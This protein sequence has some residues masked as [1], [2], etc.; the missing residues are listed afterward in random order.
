VAQRCL[1]GK[2]G[3]EALIYFPER[4]PMSTIGGGGWGAGCWDLQAEMAM[5]AAMAR[6][7]CFMV[8]VVV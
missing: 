8:L 6:M 2:L 7:M 3:D 4:M 1:Q 5:M